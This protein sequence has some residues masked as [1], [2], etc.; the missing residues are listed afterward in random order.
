MA[1]AYRDPNYDVVELR[2]LREPGRLGRQQ[3]ENP[4]RFEMLTPKSHLKALL[5]FADNK[6]THNARAC[7]RAQARSSH[8]RCDRDADRQMISARH[9]R[10]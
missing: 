9:G 6:E 7:R 2:E 10:C 3:Q 5:N 1:E 4:E 8:R